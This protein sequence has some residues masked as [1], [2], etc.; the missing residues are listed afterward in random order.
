MRPTLALALAVTF[1]SCGFARAAPEAPPRQVITTSTLFVTVPDLPEAQRK[2]TTA[3]GAVGGFV[4]GS[5]LFTAQKEGTWR[6]RVPS[7]RLDEAVSAL[8]ALG[9]VSSVRTDA[10]DVTD[11]VVDVDARLAAKRAEEARLLELLKT[12]SASLADVLAVEKELSRVRGEVEALAGQQKR[13][14]T[15]VAMS[16]LTVTLSAER[17]GSPAFTSQLGD[18][19]RGSLGAMATTARVS[20]LALVA[21]L[22]WVLP[23]A[24]AVALIRRRRRS[25]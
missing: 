15:D 6:L 1:A 4:E 21:V 2:L 16:S 14:A 25:V 3:V 24:L 11:E 13:L 7:A 23:V 9:D 10:R 18:T 5:E 12:A 17:L 20:V 19:L 22:P 8:S